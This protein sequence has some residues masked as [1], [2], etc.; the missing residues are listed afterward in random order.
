[1][2][3]FS[4]SLLE[5][6]DTYIEGESSCDIFSLPQNFIEVNGSVTP[7]CSTF[8][9]NGLVYI[10]KIFSEKSKTSFVSINLLFRKNCSVYSLEIPQHVR[11]TH[12]RVNQIIP[13]CSLG[14][15]D[16]VAP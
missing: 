13:P 7:V 15:V 14:G 8:D 11:H 3:I 6:I 10:L 16:V 2:S 1:M 5:E 12:T 9:G 4:Q